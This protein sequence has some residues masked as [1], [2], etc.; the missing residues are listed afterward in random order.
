M[1]KIIK[2]PFEAGKSISTAIKKLVVGQY[3][4]GR[5]RYY[6]SAIATFFIGN[7]ILSAE[8]TA[9]WIELT[10]EAIP[11][12]LMLLIT[13]ISA[14]TNDVVKKKKAESEVIEEVSEEKK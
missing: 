11:E 2:L 1:S 9:K 7:K 8:D 10:Q 14:K 6:L 12:L 3:V 13:W 4:K 5:I